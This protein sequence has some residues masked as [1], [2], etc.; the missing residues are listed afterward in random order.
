MEEEKRVREAEI[1]RR[2][3]ERKKRHEKLAV[4]GKKSFFELEQNPT[5]A[6]ASESNPVAE[7]DSTQGQN[8]KF[9]KSNDENTPEIMDESKLDEIHGK[10]ENDLNAL[11]YEADKDD[12]LDGSVTET[13]LIV[14][15][16][17]ISSKDNGKLTGVKQNDESG[18]SDRK[19]VSVKKSDRKK[20]SRTKSLERKSK[21]KS[22]SRSRSSRRYAARRDRDR[23]DVYRRKN[24]SPYRD[25][26]RRRDDYRNKRFR[27]DRSR[28]RSR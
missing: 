2:E 13:S 14:Q 12:N 16:F 21:K 25:N 7:I 19:D 24:H 20:R 9:E 5:R 3:V 8:E 15:R 10:N 4:S 23:R 1:K 26:N 27:R 6:N 11:D 17:E 18:K 22:K 28:K